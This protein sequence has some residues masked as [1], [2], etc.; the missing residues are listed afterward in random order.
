MYEN[1]QNINNLKKVISLYKKNFLQ[2]VA[3]IFLLTD[4]IYT[5]T[6]NISIKIYEM[7]LSINFLYI[8]TKLLYKKNI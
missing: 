2:V 5:L 8:T 7:C 1:I 3:N 4:I 6:Y